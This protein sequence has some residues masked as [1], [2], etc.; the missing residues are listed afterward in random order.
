MDDSPKRYGSGYEHRPVYTVATDNST[1]HTT[2][3]LYADVFVPES[4]TL[5]MDFFD[6]INTMPPPPTY[7]EAN[8]S[9]GSPPEYSIGNPYA[10]I[11]V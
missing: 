6:L 9:Q 2:E 4:V 5:N 7:A 3:N 10:I 1:M 8:Q 11:N